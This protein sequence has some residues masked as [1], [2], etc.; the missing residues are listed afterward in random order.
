MLNFPFDSPGLVRFP[1][2]LDAIPPAP[3]LTLLQLLTDAIGDQG[4]KPAAKGH[5]PR[6]FCRDAALAYWGERRYQGKNPL[7]RHQSAG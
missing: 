6:N 1:K 2:V 7:W 3:L 5:L 4:L